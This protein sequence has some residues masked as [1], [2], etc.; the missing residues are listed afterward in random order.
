[1]QQ[2][3][4]RSLPFL[5]AFCAI[6][7][8][9][10]SVIPSDELP[11]LDMWEPDKIVHVIFYLTLTILSIHLSRSKGRQGLLKS[12]IIPAF[13][14]ILYSICIELIQKALP[15]RSFDI[16]DVLAN[17]IGS[18]LAMVVVSVISGRKG[19]KV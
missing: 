7:I 4:Y 3:Y 16:Y 1:M 10:L 11:T 9:V 8:L 14:C 2:L 13:V 6:S 5:V 15:T 19:Q 17:T 18:A 12:V